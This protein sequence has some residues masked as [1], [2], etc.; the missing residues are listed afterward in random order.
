M[1]DDSM[2]LKKRRELI[3]AAKIIAA[4]L[5]TAFAFAFLMGTSCGVPDDP[6]TAEDWFRKGK[7]YAD[8]EMY[9]KAIECLTKA[10]EIDPELAEAYAY[11]GY[12]YY[13]MIQY[14]DA[15]QD[16]EKAMKLDTIFSEITYYY[17]GRSY[18]NVENYEKAVE[19]FSNAI[20]INP[21][22]ADYYY[23]R[24]S[25]YRRLNLLEEAE[26]NFRKACSLGDSNGCDEARFL[27]KDRIED[28]RKE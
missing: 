17:M 25:S 27:F 6:K 3:V 28:K 4:V 2:K 24:A 26:E 18:Y 9:G 15:I 13:R 16:L 1:K 21:E 12:S 23:N 22:E 14:E 19:C 11:R 5:V 8:D 7:A 20:E 10:I